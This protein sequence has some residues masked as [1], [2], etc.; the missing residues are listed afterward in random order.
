MLNEMRNNIYAAKVNAIIHWA[1]IQ[2]SVSW[3]NG[4]PNPGTAF[5]V[6]EDGS[7]QVEPG[8]YYYKQLSRAGQP[9]MGVVRVSSKDTQVCPIAFSSNGT[10][11]GGNFALLNLSD[12]VKQPDIVL[13]GNK[14]SGSQ[15][16]HSSPSETYCSLGHLSASEQSFPIE[17]PPLS[18]TTFFGRRIIILE[19]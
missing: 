3:K 15:I 9:G 14:A 13:T 11:N 7:Y 17:L 4:D 8:Y 10:R 12:E 2:W 16:Y 1:G 6:L 19:N 18:V 5:R